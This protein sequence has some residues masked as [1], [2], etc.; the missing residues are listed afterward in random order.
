MQLSVT[1]LLLWPIKSANWPPCH[2]CRS[3]MWRFPDVNMGVSL[4]DWWKLSSS[5]HREELMFK[6]LSWEQ[7]FVVA[8]HSH[9]VW[10]LATVGKWWKIYSTLNVISQRRQHKQIRCLFLHAQVCICHNIYHHLKLWLS[11]LFSRSALQLVSSA[12]NTSGRKYWLKNKTEG[13][14]IVF[15][16]QMLSN[17]LWL[18]LQ[19]TKLE[20]QSLHSA[21]YALLLRELV[22]I[23]KTWMWFLMRVNYRV[24][25]IMNKVIA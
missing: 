6:L 10:Q 23:S 24:L 15:A 9:T 25:V 13:S 16:L 20:S 14:I 21:A 1:G 5:D 7:I 11:I 19:H 3:V 2:Y 18:N 4:L 12:K 22:A 8:G 17:I